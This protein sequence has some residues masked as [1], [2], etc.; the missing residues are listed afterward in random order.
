MDFTDLLDSVLLTSMK[1]W[2]PFYFCML[3]NM[4]FDEDNTKELFN[5][6]FS[7]TDLMSSV[8]QIEHIPYQPVVEETT[9]D[10]DD[11]LAAVNKI[12]QE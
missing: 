3:F 11:L 12:E 7:D 9:M 8:E 5:S 10:D 2:D 4:E 6:S 1:N